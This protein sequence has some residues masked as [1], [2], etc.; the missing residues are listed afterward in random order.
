LTDRDDD[1]KRPPERD[2]EAN[3]RA[4]SAVRPPVLGSV[5]GAGVHGLPLPGDASWQPEPEAFAK[6]DELIR[7]YRGNVV[8][9]LEP[10]VRAH[11]PELL[12]T[13]EYGKMLELSTK[14][15]LVGH[16]ACEIAG[17][18]YNERRQTI[19]TLFGG[20][21]FLADSFVDDF[22]PAA[23][24]EY[25]ERIQI[26][27][28]TG[29]FDVR[30]ARERLFYAIVARLFAARDVLDP[31]LRQAIMLLFDAQKRDCE[32][33]L[34]LDF[35]ALPRRQQLRLLRLCA[36]DRSGHA[37]T[38]LTG[39]VAPRIEVSMLPY[40]FT[41]GALIMHIDDHGDCYADLRDGR[42]TYLNQVRNPAATL[43]KL[44]V[45][46]VARLHAGLPP[47]E[48]RDLMLAFLTRYFLT[49]V[50][51]HRLQKERA[52]SAWAVYE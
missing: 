49:R 15:T 2:R 11:Y 52:D 32:L 19:G 17:Y 6:V 45:E 47:S 12:A 41:A 34:S 29:W 28:T 35:A 25:L 44:F 50:E 51:K 1:G 3:D 21:C 27:L 42:L 30:T 38:V 46:H 39:F 31:I 36:R 4:H 43:R 14:M 37:I 48:G 20:C 8:A 22:G 23:T 26:L 24:H 10:T 9:C 40:L 13:L 16:A 33:R 7:G 18:R 5:A